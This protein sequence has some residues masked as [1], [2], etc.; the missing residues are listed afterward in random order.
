M[1]IGG[2]GGSGRIGIS[3]GRGWTQNEC[4]ARMHVL[5]LD[6]PI[7]A[8]RA[9]QGIRAGSDRAGTRIDRGRL[10]VEWWCSSWSRG[11]DWL[12]DGGY[13]QG[14]KPVSAACCVVL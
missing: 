1:G 10:S 4:D 2:S 5:L 12:R 11:G 6:L 3:I 9:G 8:A 14:D 13:R 7:I